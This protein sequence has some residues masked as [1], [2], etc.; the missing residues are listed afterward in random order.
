MVTL[1]NR[2]GHLINCN[3]NAGSVLSTF[4]LRQVAA[5][6]CFTSDKSELP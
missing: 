3:S 5:V 6:K 1:L 2:L 4:V